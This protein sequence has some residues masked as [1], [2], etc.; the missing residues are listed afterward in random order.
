MAMA[1]RYD[2]L[3]MEPVFWGVIFCFFFGLAVLHI[4]GTS[5]TTGNPGMRI[6]VEMPDA[7]CPEFEIKLVSDTNFGKKIEWSDPFFFKPSSISVL[8]DGSF[9]AAFSNRHKIY[10]FDRSGDFSFE[11][12]QKGLGPGDFNLPGNLSVLDGK[13]LVVNEYATNRRISLFDLNGKFNKLIK[14]TYPVEDSI[15]LKD[16]KIAILSFNYTESTR[17]LSVYIRDIDSGQE[18]AVLSTDDRMRKAGETDLLF[19]ASDIQQRGFIHRTGIG[20]LLVG[21]SYNK[22]IDIYSPDGKKVT[23]FKLKMDETPVTDEVISRYKDCVIKKIKKNFKNPEMF[24]KSFRASRGIK[25]LFSEYLPFYNNLLIDSEG[26]I[27]VFYFTFEPKGNYLEFQVYNA[28]GKYLCDSKLDFGDFKVIENSPTLKNRIEF[29]GGRLYAI[30]DQEID[31]DVC[32]KI[33]KINLEK[34]NG[35][36]NEENRKSL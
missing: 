22:I 33:V 36:K 19:M 24:L 11:F 8:A 16:N 25:N 13:Y 20:N 30:L 9:F 28:E 3:V 34:F 18:V 29:S 26:N 4:R 7:G 1:K 10:K 35:G 2:K 32:Q 12:G 15:A 31:G 6:D 5:T 21:F 14:T 27:L 17:R 23:S